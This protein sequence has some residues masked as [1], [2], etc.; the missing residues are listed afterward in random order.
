VVEEDFC[1]LTER[2]SSLV[3]VG[4]LMEATGPLNQL[5]VLR[6]ISGLVF[7]GS[8]VSIIELLLPRLDILGPTSQINI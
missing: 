8:K 3:E 7:V 4:S 6:T 5:L 1:P 2:V